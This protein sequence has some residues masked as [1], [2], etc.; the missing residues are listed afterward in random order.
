M[1]EFSLV[2]KI[3]IWAIPVL[4]AITVHEVA[5]GWVALK[6]GDRTAQMLGRLT[7]NP[8]K[9]IDP[10]GT[11]LVPGLLLLLGGFVFGWAKPVPVSYQNL[12]QPKR[13]MAWVAAAG[14]AANF[15]MAIIWAIVAKLGLMLIHADITLGQPMMFMGVAGVLI[16]TML[17]MLNLLPIPPLDGSRVLSSWLPGP[18]A[19]KF[20]RIEP[21]GFFILLGLLYFGILNLILWPLVSAMLGLL[22]SVFHLPAQIF[23]IL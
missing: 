9:H 20:S 23:S 13:D 11:V 5:H 1:F 21:Y 22:V 19:Y 8:F 10:I 14:P 17:M 15:I 18:M 16:N 2:Q 6:L 7:L 4:F 12:H 3:I